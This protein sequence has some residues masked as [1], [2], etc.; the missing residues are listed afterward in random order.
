MTNEPTT[1]E[2]KQMHLALITPFA[3]Y[4][5][6]WIPQA[7]YKDQA[8]AACYI[9]ARTVMDRLDEVFGA[10]GWKDEYQPA[11]GGGLNCR[12]HVRW[13]D[14]E[15]TFHEGFGAPGGGDGI[16]SDK[17]SESD[18]LK[19]AAVKYG[20]GRYLYRIPTQWIDCELKANGKFKRFKREPE[21]PK[22]AIP[23]SGG[24]G[25]PPYQEEVDNDPDGS[26]PVE[27]GSGPNRQTGGQGTG[28]PSEPPEPAKAA[29][30]TQFK[31]KFGMHKGKTIA[32]I[33]SDPK[34]A[35]WLKWALEKLGDD[36]R[37]DELLATIRA[38]LGMVDSPAPQQ[39]AQGAATSPAPATSVPHW[40]KDDK[41]RRKYHAF[42]NRIGLT[43]HEAHEALEVEHTEEFGGDMNDAK[44][45]LFTYAEQIVEDWGGRADMLEHWTNW[46]KEMNYTFPDAQ[47][48]LTNGAPLKE[49]KGTMAVAKNVVQAALSS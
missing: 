44:L 22:W 32:E 26:A 41:T 37:N 20:I 28:E 39:P 45:A 14:G 16:D 49:F 10:D 3:A 48:A 40:I 17:S 47:A 25:L 30:P 4:Y 34:D 36:D 2:I 46:L 23:Q 24:D 35:G 29:D 27:H 18:S 5:V 6:K 38:Y 12:L 8:L 19:R 7:V 33:G 21:L 43:A 42:I 13:A 9:D 15:W 31:L 11:H 1:D